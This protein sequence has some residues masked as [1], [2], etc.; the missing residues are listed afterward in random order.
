MSDIK[1]PCTEL[2]IIDD[3]TGLCVGCYRTSDEIAGWSD[4]N[5]EKKREILQEI[6]LRADKYKFTDS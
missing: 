1:S 2:C 5:Y 6:V 4:F 3:D